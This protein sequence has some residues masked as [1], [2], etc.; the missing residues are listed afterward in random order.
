MEAAKVLAQNSMENAPALDKQLDYISLRGSFPEP[1]TLKERD[2]A[3]KG[4]AI[5]STTT[6]RFPAMLKSLLADR[7]AKARPGA[8]SRCFLLPS[9]C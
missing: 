4:S 1:L 8:G 9:P 7:R 6:L 2:A 3:Q 5:F